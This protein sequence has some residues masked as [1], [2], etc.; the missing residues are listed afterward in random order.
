MGDPSEAFGR[1]RNDLL[2]ISGASREA[3]ELPEMSFGLDFHGFSLRSNNPG[4]LENS[5]VFIRREAIE[6]IPSEVPFSTKCLWKDL[7]DLLEVFGISLDV[8]WRSLGGLG[9]SFG[10]VL[11]VLGC[12]WEVFGRFITCPWR[13]QTLSFSL[14]FP[15]K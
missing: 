1:S 3:F 7:R 4:D 12:S 8:L 2:R 5:E 6:G 14:D 9:M 15:S 10:C 11:Y 13:V